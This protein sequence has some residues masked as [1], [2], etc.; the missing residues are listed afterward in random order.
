[1]HLL[2]RHGVAPRGLAGGGR[3]GLGAGQGLGL[4]RPANA[5]LHRGGRAQVGARRHRRDMAGVEDV[6]AGTGRARAAGIDIAGHRH[7]R[8]QDGLDD[9]AHRRVQPARGV[10]FQHH[11][12]GAARARAFHA[13]QDKAGAGGADRTLERNHVDRRGCRGR[14]RGGGRRG[15]GGRSRTGAWTGEGDES[16]ARHGQAGKQPAGHRPKDPQQRGSRFHEG[17]GAREVP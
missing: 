8:G 9:L 17:G 1:M 5:D 14:D 4:L 12:L 3:G 6:G 13:A 16:G 15:A 7:R 10:H 2:A 11:Q